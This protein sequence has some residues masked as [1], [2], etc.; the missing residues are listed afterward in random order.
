LAHK[1]GYE[2]AKGYS[3]DYSDLQIRELHKLQ[4]KYDNFGRKNP[5]LG[6]IR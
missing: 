6:R 2:A 5:D 4:H 1:R 3:Y